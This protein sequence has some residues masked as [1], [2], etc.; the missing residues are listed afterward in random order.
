[1]ERHN[2]HILSCSSSEEEHHSF[3]N[4]ISTTKNISSEN[5]L[6]SKEEEEKND[7]SKI[8]INNYKEIKS[9][10]GKENDLTNVISIDNN[11]NDISQK[12]EKQEQ[13]TIKKNDIQ[14]ED[15]LLIMNNITNEKEKEEKKE[16]KEVDEKEKEKNE[17]G[18]E[19][20]EGEKLEEPKEESIE[21][22]ENKQKKYMLLNNGIVVKK[23]NK[24]V[25][26][27]KNI[28]NSEQNMKDNLKEKTKNII[29]KEKK[30][31]EIKDNKNNVKDN[32][33][34]K[35][36]DNKNKIL[37]IIQS[38]RCFITKLYISKT[39]INN[40]E[41]NKKEIK[42]ESRSINYSKI[43]SKSN[44]EKYNKISIKS[45]PAS[46]LN[47][48][49]KNPLV[50][51]NSNTLNRNIKNNKL[52]ENF[53]SLSTLKKNH[54]SVYNN[55]NLFFSST[56]QNVKR[57]QRPKSSYNII[58]KEIDLNLKSSKL[59]TKIDTSFYNQSFSIQK[60]AQISSIINTKTNINKIENLSQV[61][62]N[63][64]KLNKNKFKKEIIFEN[65]NFLKDLKELKNAFEISEIN[66]NKDNYNSKNES[67][68][69]INMNNNIEENVLSL[70]RRKLN[71]AKVKGKSYN[72]FYPKDPSP[73]FFEF[74]KKNYYDKEGKSNFCS[75][76]GYKKHFGNEKDCPLCQS[77][78]ENSKKRERELSNLN[79]YY[80]FKDKNENN[81]SKQ[82]SF[83]SNNNSINKKKQINDNYNFTNFINKKMQNKLPMDCYYNPFKISYINSY[84]KKRKRKKDLL[85]INSA[86]Q[87]RNDKD[88][89]HQNHNFDFEN[90]LRKEI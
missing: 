88:N 55:S 38:D 69:N 45:R 85:R 70:K 81:T 47:R 59:E 83:R 35:N 68:L 29:E 49:I 60:T 52:K 78:R 79:Y 87:I 30:E 32:H 34:I 7:W 67:N 71:S 63:R 26:S 13:Q 43:T 76:C 84:L 54:L 44:T 51:N 24:K 6:I 15:D 90:Y 40:N 62:F 53:S 2:T 31:E 5:L 3:R 42:K 8:I 37:S 65:Q 11:I 73:L 21:K 20:E 82:N 17:K 22:K 41:K 12:Q 64:R 46:S 39:K 89:L 16:K 75:K 23:I 1:M 36:N 74:K 80:R 14:N 66:L 61:S 72:V 58:K 27:P 50:K 56:N 77:V 9:K 48:N 19:G 86:K 33:L 18:D 4:N 25:E 28:K 57:K 10:I